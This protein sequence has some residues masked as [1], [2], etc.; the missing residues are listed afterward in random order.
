MAEK[1]LSEVNGRKK[2]RMNS[3]E[4]MKKTISTLEDKVQELE[5][6]SNSKF[7]FDL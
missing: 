3:M 4:A 7:S 2:K 5:V 1:V 6:S